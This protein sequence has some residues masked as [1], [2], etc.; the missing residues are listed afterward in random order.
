MLEK[1]PESI[2]KQKIELGFSPIN[3]KQFR[4]HFPQYDIKLYNDTLIHHHIGGGGQAVAVPSKLH[5]GSG[6]IHNAEKEAGI[7]GSDSQ[8]AELLEKFL[9]K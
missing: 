6:G 1:Y 9:N 3:D 7:W 5:P 4:E 2:S 8:Y